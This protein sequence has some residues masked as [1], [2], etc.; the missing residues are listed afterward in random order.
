MKP[1][2]LYYDI[3][4][5][6][7]DNKELLKRNFEVISIN[8]PA[9][10]NAAVLHEIDGLFAPLGYACGKE[11]IDMCHNL[12]IIGS[13]T[14]SA[15]HIDRAYAREK[16][17]KVAYLGPEVEFLRTITPTAEHTWGLLL[18]LLR[19]TPWAF[20]SVRQGQWNRFDW[21]AD[22]MLSRMSLGIVGL[23]RLGSLVGKYAKAF[24]MT[25]YFFDPYVEQAVAP[26]IEKFDTLDELVEKSD[27]V[28]LHLHHTPET[29]GMFDDRLFK[30]F[31]KGAYL[32]NTAR[33]AIVNTSSLIQALEDGRLAGA[34]MDVLDDEFE[35]DFNKSVIEH[36]LV[37]H[38]I[39]HDNVIITPH[40]AGSTK[41]AWNLTQAYTINMI[42][43]YFNQINS[44]ESRS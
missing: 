28:T 23:G 30:K 15:P 37:E 35:S 38:S 17:I 36:P 10:D 3:L 33:G 34:A 6:S 8:N 29:T 4:N 44:G 18:A 11:K 16:G 19:K 13:N 1:K 21:G 12:K 24:N 40:I 27:I 5:F 42:S 32:I 41:D 14:T 7:E 2:I 26:D 31:K 22:R 25:V 9:E 39:K 43:E 20:D